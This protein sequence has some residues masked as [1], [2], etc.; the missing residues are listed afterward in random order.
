MHKLQNRKMMRSNR[1]D[2]RKV[3][4]CFKCRNNMHCLNIK[5]GLLK[6]EMHSVTEAARLGITSEILQTAFYSLRGTTPHTLRPDYKFFEENIC[7]GNGEVVH[8]VISIRKKNYK[9]FTPNVC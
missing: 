3:F 6:G 1:V 4:V 8:V 9:K 5:R 7:N 2:D